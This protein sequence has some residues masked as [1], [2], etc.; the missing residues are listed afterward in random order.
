MAA[1]LFQEIL[2]QNTA[3]AGLML[4]AYTAFEDGNTARGAVVSFV[5]AGFYSGS[6][7][8]SVSAAHKY[9]HAQRRQILDREYHFDTAIDP[10]N[11][12]ILFSFRHMF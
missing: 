10:V 4:A 1:R 5:G 9:N 12:A 11:Q 6:I 8:G 3:D 7:Y 2:D